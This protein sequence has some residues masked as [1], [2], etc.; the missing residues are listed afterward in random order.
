MAHDPM[1]DALLVTKVA[2]KSRLPEFA[3]II[4]A[5]FNEAEAK[6]Y[7]EEAAMTAQ[8]SSLDLDEQDLP[9]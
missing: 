7:A 2:L 3:K 9:F 5:E 6:L 4:E 8:S 1:L